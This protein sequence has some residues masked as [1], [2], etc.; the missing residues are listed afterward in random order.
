M[1][2]L[3]KCQKRVQIRC[4]KKWKE[5]SVGMV[6][7]DCLEVRELKLGL[8]ELEREKNGG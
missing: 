5:D 8:K 4:T 2:Y 6:S 3:V 1:Q 7:A